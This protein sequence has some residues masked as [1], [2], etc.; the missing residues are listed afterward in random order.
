MIAGKDFDEWWT[1]RPTRDAPLAVGDLDTIW[2]ELSARCDTMDPG[3]PNKPPS[4][5][6][7]VSFAAALVTLGMLGL[8]VVVQAVAHLPIASA[9][10][11]TI[12][13]A[14]AGVIVRWRLDYPARHLAT[15]W[16]TGA[17]V[18]VAILLA[19]LITS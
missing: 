8:W 11:V 2:N 16:T 19:A 3:Q 14:L 17:I 1:H 10:A 13:A 9:A 18:G 12:V 7:V 15:A 6:G 4:L 5:L